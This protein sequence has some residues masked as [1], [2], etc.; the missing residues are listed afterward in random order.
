MI[1]THP[2]LFAFLLFTFLSCKENKV[3]TKINKTDSTNNIS[4]KVKSF[5]SKIEKS[6]IKPT[7]STRLDSVS[8][9]DPNLKIE[10]YIKNKK[11]FIEI[12]SEKIDINKLITIN[13]VWSKKD[14]VD[15]ANQISEV[16]YYKSLNLVLL[17][18]DFDMCTGLG[19]GVNYQLIYDLNSKQV[20]PFGRFRT[21][22]DMNLYK[23]KDDVYYLSKTF[24]GRNAQLKDTIFFN[25]YKIEPKS[26]PQKE[27]KYFARFTYDNED[28]EKET[29]FIQNWIKE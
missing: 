12:N 19:C 15:Y 10:S 27:E 20:Y 14:S 16:K 26:I 5:I 9:F 13:D 4:Q 8:I 29:S 22:L 3:E 1:K 21:G 11:F 28:Y 25:L 7:F 2:F 17:L 6:E 23:F 24:H 18:L